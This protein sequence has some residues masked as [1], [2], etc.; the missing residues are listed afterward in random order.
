MSHSERGRGKYVTYYVIYTT[1]FVIGQSCDVI[2]GCVISGQS[3]DV[4]IG[5]VISGQSC[6]VII[7]CVINGQSCD[8]IIKCVINGESY[9]TVTRH[10]NNRLY[11]S[12]ATNVTN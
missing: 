7:K 10:N 6:D 11:R 5:C 4:I 9:V 8:V 12:Y 1:V 2:I 3:Y